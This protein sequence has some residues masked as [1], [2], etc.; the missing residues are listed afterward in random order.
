MS[1]KRNYFAS[2]GSGGTQGV[3]AAHTMASIAPSKGLS[4]E[5]GQNS[6]FLNSA[7]QLSGRSDWFLLSGKRAAS[8]TCLSSD[9]SDETGRTEPTPQNS[10]FGP[11]NRPIRTRT[12]ALQRPGP[13]PL[14]G[15]ALGVPRSCE[16]TVQYQNPAAYWTRRGGGTEEQTELSQH[17]LPGPFRF[18][19]CSARLCFWFPLNRPRCPAR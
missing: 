5:P 14:P 16:Q 4:N 1:W 8:R 19:L 7:L 13:V 3:V 10:L 15:S 2:G 17:F 11:Q 12:A 18:C 9:G 6:C